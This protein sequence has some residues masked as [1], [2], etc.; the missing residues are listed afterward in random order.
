[1]PVFY[2]YRLAFTSQYGFSEAGY[3]A[4]LAYVLFLVILALTL[5]Q[6][7]LGNR[8]VHYSS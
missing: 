6:F 4:A 1:V 5:V 7:W 2:I 3:A 8:V